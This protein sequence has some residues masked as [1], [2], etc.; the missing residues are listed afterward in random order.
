MRNKKINQN[1]SYPSSE[2]TDTDAA[3]SAMASLLDTE[4]PQQENNRRPVFALWLLSLAASIVLCFFLLNF[5]R[6]NTA[7]SSDFVGDFECVESSI[8]SPNKQKYTNVAAPRKSINSSKQNNF[9]S[10]KIDKNSS[11]RLENRT[12]STNN[13]KRE[14]YIPI[15][16]TNNVDND[17]TGI[18][19]AEDTERA[20][21]YPVTES[22]NSSICELQITPKIIDFRTTPVRQNI[23][24]NKSYTIN[25]VAAANYSYFRNALGLGIGAEVNFLIAKNLNFGVAANYNFFANKSKEQQFYLAEN[26]S[27]TNS[28]S[29]N[30]NSVKSANLST[31]NYFHQIAAPI[32]LQYQ[33]LN[34]FSFRLGAVPSFIYYKNQHSIRQHS[35][36]DNFVYD[37]FT[38]EIPNSSMSQ[39]IQ[40]DILT[41]VQWQ[42]SHRATLFCSFQKS[43]SPNLLQLSNNVGFGAQY[44][45][46]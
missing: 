22:L 18:K 19:K 33:F 10:K 39:L 23:T 17:F 31:I 11:N 12:I 43:T 5:Y 6:N 30:S 36:N 13:T 41:Q 26:S 14:N 44:Q 45:L 21:N 16:E 20:E 9:L 2:H 28:S 34:K 7:K 8:Y 40:L 38:S 1:Q 29:N 37:A 35:A 25:L 4:L 24:K 32:Y 3:W 27:L 46:K 15:T 42:I